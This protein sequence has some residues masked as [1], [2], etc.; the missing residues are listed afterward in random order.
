[1]V[2]PFLPS[3]QCSWTLILLISLSLV[4][5]ICSASQVYIAQGATPL[6]DGECVSPSCTADAPCGLSTTPITLNDSCEIIFVEKVDVAQVII[7][8][9]GSGLISLSSALNQSETYPPGTAIKDNAYIYADTEF[10]LDAPKATVVLNS[11]I[12]NSSFLSFNAS[13]LEVRSSTLILT[14][15]KICDAIESVSVHD[16]FISSYGGS[17]IQNDFFTSPKVNLSFYDSELIDESGFGK[18]IS[19]SE[20]DSDNGQ[21]NIYIERSQLRYQSLIAGVPGDLFITDTHLTLGTTILYS[22]RTAILATDLRLLRCTIRG[23]RINMVTSV[24]AYRLGTYNFKALKIDSLDAENFGLGRTQSPSITISGSKFNNSV[25]ACFGNRELKDPVVLTNVDGNSTISI[26]SSA[27]FTYSEAVASFANSPSYYSHLFIDSS[28]IF[29]NSLTQIDNGNHFLFTT[30][31]ILQTPLSTRNL[32]IG[33]DVH[34]LG[35]PIAISES[36]QSKLFTT[37]TL[38]TTLPSTLNSILV[39]NIATLKSISPLIYR[40]TDIRQG[41]RTSGVVNSKELILQIPAESTS[42]I[43]LGQT[44]PLFKTLQNVS[45]TSWTPSTLNISLVSLQPSNVGFVFSETACPSAC[46]AEHTDKCIDSSICTCAAPWSG[47]NCECNTTSMPDSLTCDPTGGATWIDI[48]APVLIDSDFQ[49]PSGH[50]MLIRGDLT[51]QSQGHLPSAASVE[52]LGRMVID[53]RAELNILATLQESLKDNSRQ[54]QSCSI[55]SDTSVIVRSQLVIHK[56]S[57]VKIGIDI[58]NLSFNKICSPPDLSL[59]GLHN[60]IIASENS[61]QIDQWS[62]WEITISDS[63]STRPEDFSYILPLLLSNNTE[64]SMGRVRIKG[65]V[66]FENTSCWNSLQMGDNDANNNPIQVPGLDNGSI[67]LYTP[68][69][70]FE[71]RIIPTAN[72]EV[73]SGSSTRWLRWGLPVIIIGS[74]ALIAAAVLVAIVIFKPALSKAVE[75]PL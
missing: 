34:I 62:D 52:V 8:Y 24:V 1:M 31:V 42:S 59:T 57:E 36:I 72:I 27:F 56:N 10:K 64:E 70:L 25:E 75:T 47:P 26:T 17:M 19:V 68:C 65:G 20:F 16:S 46:V 23:T 13:K 38:E 6:W 22:R 21:T 73:P 11:L 12:S 60:S 9:S 33:S 4:L 66:K 28:S 41:I 44:Y 53:T 67:M 37:V 74:L 69:D 63:A 58:S 30:D 18:M 71:V 2:R 55:S 15:L 5:S 43:Q 40:A 49:L 14:Q 3:H 39:V 29:F 35:A 51:L 50:K 61:T 48:S 45:L 7:K 54:D 32:L